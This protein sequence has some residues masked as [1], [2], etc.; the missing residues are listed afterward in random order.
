MSRQPSWFS[1]PFRTV[2]KKSVY[3]AGEFFG[4]QYIFRIVTGYSFLE[5]QR[6]DKAGVFTYSA[7]DGTE[8]AAL[9]GQISEDV[10]QQ[11]YHELMSLQCKISEEINQSLEGK[12]LDVLIEGSDEEQKNVAYGRSYREAP[13]VDGQVFVEGLEDAQPGEIVRARV[14]QGFTYDVV[15][16]PIA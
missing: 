15:C 14:S 10:M 2:R 13:E 5:E 4:F 12:E 16:E 6:F 11:R 1:N 8:A 3:D 9:S 7:E